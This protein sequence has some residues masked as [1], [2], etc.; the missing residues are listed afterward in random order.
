MPPNIFSWFNYIACVH[1]YIDWESWKL[2]SHWNNKNVVW[3]YQIRSDILIIFKARQK[4]ENHWVLFKCVKKSKLQSHNI[5][6]RNYQGDTKSRQTTF[7]KPFVEQAWFWSHPWTLA[8]DVLK[9]FS[10]WTF[11]FQVLSYSGWKQFW[12]TEGVKVTLICPP[13]LSYIMPLTACRVYYEKPIVEGLDGFQPEVT[14]NRHP[15]SHQNK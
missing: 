11:E 9:T 7:L 14:V 13:I 10:G 3:I 1:G 15:G 6:L 8:H 5:H 4:E 12:L 2:I